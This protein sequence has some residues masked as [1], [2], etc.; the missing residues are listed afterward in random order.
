VTTQTD[1]ADAEALWAA[2]RD[3][4]ANVE[5]A[6]KA[7]IAAKAWK[8][9]GF[10]TFAQA[11]DARMKGVTLANSVK[12]Y[13]IYAMLDDHVPLDDIAG[14]TGWGLDQVSRAAEDYRIGVPVDGATVVRQHFR[15]APSERKTVHVTFESGEMFWLNEVAKR[16]GRSVH[17]EAKR[18]IIA[19]FEAM[20]VTLD[21]RRAS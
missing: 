19:H 21:E 13:V 14:A 3:T 4:L 20:E 10:E 17:E 7:V 6:I 1:T 12:P 9:L 2:V 18:A 8:P 5:E 15:K 11:W 16:T